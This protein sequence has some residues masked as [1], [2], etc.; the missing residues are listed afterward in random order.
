[1]AT[2]PQ[3][4]IKIA[5]N[6][7]DLKTAMAQ[8]RQ[9]VIDQTEATKA[10][11]AATGGW[12]SVLDTL[13]GSF[14]ARVTEGVLLR[15]A[16]R[17]VITA[18][19][20]LL[21]FFPELAMRGSVVGDVEA[22][23]HRLTT[24]AGLLSDELLGT[25][26]AGTHGTIDDFALM[27]RTNKDLAAGLNLTQDQF[28]L[29]TQGAFALA[30]ATG[31]S[32]AEA[33]DKMSDA[34]VTGRTK[35]IALLTGK[36]D[37]K[38]A[39][40]AFAESLGVTAKELS[41]EGKLEADR[42]AILA[43]V[44][45]GLARVGDQQD[46]LKDKVEQSHVRWANFTDELGKSIA[47]SPVIAAGFDTLRTS[48]AAAFGGDQKALIDHVGLAINEAAILVVDFGIA[49]VQGVG[50][51]VTAFEGLRGT[52][53]ATSSGLLGLSMIEHGA[54][55]DGM[56]VMAAGVEE[57]T[58]IIK[59]AAL[60]HSAFQ[61]TLEKVGGALFQTRDAMVAA[62]LAQD[63]QTASTTAFV[64]PLQQ[65]GVAVQAHGNFLKDVTDKTKAFDAAVLEV[66]S[67]GIGWK[68]TLD[69]IDG[70]VV[71]NMRDLIAAGVS[72]KTLETY[73]GLTATQGKAFTDMLK[74]EDET[75]KQQQRSWFELQKVTDEFY[76]A[77]NAAGHDSTQRQIDDVY[78]AASARIEQM[79]KAKAYSIEAEMMIWKAAEQTADNIIAKTLE[80][81]VHSKAH[82]VK[83][84]DDA[85]IA[86]EFATAHADQYTKEWID[87]LQKTADAA[88]WAADTFG[89][90]FGKALDDV[91]GKVQGV[92]AAVKAMTLSFTAIAAGA[93]SKY[94]DT[95][96]GRLQML[97]DQRAR[98][99]EQFINTSGMFAGVPMTQARVS[100]G[101]VAGGS[102]YLVGE[103]GPELFVP[104]ASGSIVPNGGGG[105]PTIN[106]TM[107]VNGTG[108]DV[109]RIA[110]AEITKTLKQ[111]RQL[112]SV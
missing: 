52:L 13:G 32:T 35:A 110:M 25:L 39:E 11:T 95:F 112:P 105:S 19:K 87:Q 10:A 16:I 2:D 41:A 37:L 6:I 103:R 111:S 40:E 99:P 93:T 106:L 23:F 18:G 36:I 9:A 86:Y 17:E 97:A 53:V 75:L 85:R 79:T 102:P 59:D 104:Q 108:A 45:A 96:E 44:Q 15:D 46:S 61:Q 14:V 21:E 7:E 5:A 71:E 91:T 12:S 76:K 27:Q 73:Y 66:N 68:G 31:G 72:I 89:T 92:T 8:A 33:L 28:G 4:F 98:N 58:R 48:L 77:V 20:D 62:Q 42:E 55:T 69:S 60:G 88:K 94:A 1:M 90:S 30:K 54:V 50:V 65:A 84:A 57:G 24:Q 47:Q 38:A 22:S 83:L 43:H 34:M 3:M 100:G 64:G 63:K 51:A 80:S 56:K 70:A 49:T 67:A 101:P 29:L 26:R 109:A 74:D 81:D 78:L 82:F 107:Y